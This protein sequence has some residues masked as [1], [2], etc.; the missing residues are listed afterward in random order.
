MSAAPYIV[1]VPADPGDGAGFDVN[2]QAAHGFTQWACPYMGA[3]NAW[4]HPPTV[5]R[6]YE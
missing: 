1:T 6:Y 2:L 4:F 5:L 3:V